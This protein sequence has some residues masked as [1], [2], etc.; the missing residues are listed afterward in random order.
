MADHTFLVSAL[1]FLIATVVAVPLFTRLRLGSVPA[2]LV[3]GALLG[4]HVLGWIVA[5]SGEL[6]AAELGVV[7]LLFLIGM[8]LSASRLTLMR[9]ALL[10]MGPAQVAGSVLVLGVAVWL[11][12]Q[13]A[14]TALVAGFA[15]AMSSTAVGV[16]LLAERKALNT[17]YGRTVLAVLLFQDLVAVPAI[18]LMPLIGDHSAALHWRAAGWAI[19]QVVGAIALVIFFGRYLTR[20]LFRFVAGTKSQ[21]A[22]T[23]ATLMV[24]LGTAFI[25]ALA[26][27]SLAFGAF[28]A[29]VLLSESEFR[30]EIEAAI[31]P[32]KGLLLGLFFL[33]VGLT[34]DW[35]FI[36]HETLDVAIGV[37]GLLLAKSLWLYALGRRVARLDHGDS[38]RMAAVLAQGGEFA[39]VL[40]ALGARHGLMDQGARDLLTVSV[41]ISMALTPLLLLGVEAWLARARPAAAPKFDEIPDGRPRAIVAGFGRFGQIVARVLHAQRIPFVALEQDV[42]QVEASRR[43]G[44][45]IYYGDPTRP[46]VLRAAGAEHA[47]L[48]VLATDDPDTNVRT[49]RLVR[50]LYPHL[51]VYARAR[52]RQHAFRLMDMNVDYVVRETLHSSLDLAEHVLV[53]LGLSP[54]QAAVRVERFRQHDAQ[55]LLAQHLVYDDE[56]KL[57]QSAQEALADLEQLFA[58][59]E[60]EKVDRV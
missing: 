53:G 37:V 33:A 11:F 25:T 13:G 41:V 4:P 60:F 32:F 22:F 12:G 48:F 51:K 58:A 1:V 50:R 20:P 54:A 10:S 8:E 15:L 56:A 9:R 21:E 5:D 39:F 16:Q 6:A 45:A 14:R 43:F 40:L 2:Y 27:L 17:P 7:L 35:P 19:V 59:D 46:E 42:E 38:L 34:V 44:N 55:L 52:N 36:G 49:A 26:G 3:A 28:L 23:A 47:E 30:H 29:G 57:V 24:V 31:E 18:A